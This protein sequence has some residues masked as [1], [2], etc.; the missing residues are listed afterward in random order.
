M[1][2]CSPFVVHLALVLSQ[3]NMPIVEVFPQVDIIMNYGVSCTMWS[4]DPSMDLNM[5]PLNYHK[6]QSWAKSPKCKGQ[7]KGLRS[8]KN[9]ILT[10]T[11]ER[12]R[13]QRDRQ[14]DRER[15]RQADRQLERDKEPTGRQRERQGDRDWDRP[16]ETERERPRETERHQCTISYLI[17]SVAWGRTGLCLPN[18]ASVSLLGSCK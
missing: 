13:R 2:D 10:I 18:R 12:R 16:R 7:L 1:T 8:W 14:T 9:V 5:L 6:I 15:Q 4:L 3:F 11:R 17:G